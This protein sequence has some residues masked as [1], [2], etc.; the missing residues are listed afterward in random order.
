MNFRYA[1]KQFAIVAR[2]ERWFMKG[3]HGKIARGLLLVDQVYVRS[4]HCQW[5]LFFE[6]PLPGQR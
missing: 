5:M 3:P 6:P 1:Y 2:Y 4:S